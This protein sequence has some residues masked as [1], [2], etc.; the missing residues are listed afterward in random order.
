MKQSA[1]LF[2]MTCP[3]WATQCPPTALHAPLP[4]S[5]A[6][7]VLNSGPLVAPRGLLEAS[8][9]GTSL[10]PRHRQGVGKRLKSG[11]SNYLL[12]LGSRMEQWKNGG[13]G[14]VHQ[15]KQRLPGKLI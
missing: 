12:Q 6:A 3:F 11:Q 2:K 9:T 13:N 15:L 14:W 7:G 8:F 10:P 5:A 4:L 1:L